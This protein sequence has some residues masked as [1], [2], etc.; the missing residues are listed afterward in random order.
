MYKAQENRRLEW[1]D[2]TGGY[3]YSILLMKKLKGRVGAFASRFSLFGIG[4]NH[5]AFRGVFLSFPGRLG[6]SE[7][8]SFSF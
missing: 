7:R 4:W 1:P 6:T 3:S 2:R 5:K 8:L